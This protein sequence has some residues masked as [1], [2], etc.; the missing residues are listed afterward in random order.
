MVVVVAVVVVLGALLVAAIGV[1]MVSRQRLA[2][3]QA[4][5]ATAEQRVIATEAD[6][7]IKAADLEQAT[8]ERAAA[9]VLA[10]ERAER[11]RL[12]E[13]RAATIAAEALTESDARRR[14]D[15]RAEEAEAAIASYR[16]E[17]AASTTGGVAADVLWI[18]EQARSER[19]YRFS[20]APGPDSPSVFAGTSDPFLA[21]LQ[22]ELDAAR[23]DVG[24]VVELD[25]EIPG[26]LTLAATV[27]ALRAAQELVADVV[28]RSEETTLHI[29]A[30]GTDLVI[31]VESFDEHGHAVL[32]TPLPIPAS[33]AVTVTPK[34][35]RVHHAF[36]G[37]S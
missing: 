14:A 5:T 30:D 11:A 31:D 29:G 27:L 4:L 13:E 9:E 24:A 16:K 8:K 1:A 15:E 3:Q 33:T 21:A 34:G 25:A 2:S 17:A 37:V 19:T 22:V 28:R 18:L 35:V 7:A 23:E 6:L 32:P 26:G 12:A 20:V 36:A 10:T